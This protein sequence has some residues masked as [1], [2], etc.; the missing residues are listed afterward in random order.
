M[1]LTRGEASANVSANVSA[2]GSAPVS[3]SGPLRVLLA[4]SVLLPTLLFVFSSW[5]NYRSAVQDAVR[6]LERTSE[7]AREHA[8]KVFDGQAQVAERVND[9]IRGLDA[10]QIAGNEKRLHEALAGIVARLP[11][12]QSVMVASAEGRPLVSAGTYPVPRNVDLTGRDYFRAVMS[13]HEG[14]FVSSLQVGDVN[15]QLFFGMAAPWYGPG[16][17]RAGVID[18]AVSPDFFRDFYQALVNEGVGADRR[19]I[20]SLVRSDGQIL[21]RYPPLTGPPVQ[22]RGDN[23]F[24]AALR[25]QPDQGLFENASVVDPGSPDRLFYYRAVRGYPVYVVAGVARRQIRGVWEGTIARQLIFGVP[26]TVALFAVTWTALRR[27]RREEE[28]LRLARQEMRRRELA[29]QQLLHTQRLEAVGQMTGGVAHDFNNLLTIILGNAELIE[30]RADDPARVRRLASHVVLAARRGAEVTQKLLAFSRRQL[31]QPEVVDLNARLLEFREL[32]DRAAGEPVEVSF[33]LAPNLARVRLDPGQFEAA[34]LNL[35]GNAR[36]AMPEGGRVAITTRNVI[37][38]AG[39]RA[40]LADGVYAAVTVSDTGTG[41]DPATAAKAFEPFFTTKEVGRGTG[42]GLSQVY[43]FVKQ[44]GGDVRINT[45]PGAGT[46]V[47]LL[48]P[49]T[50]LAADPP[51]ADGLGS[52]GHGEVVLVVEDEKAVRDMAVE[53]LEELGYATV[54]APDAA[55]ALDRLRGPE[56]IDVLFSDVVMPGGLNGVKLATEAR[57]LRPGLRVLLTS[58]YSPD[59]IDSGLRLLR[60][61]YEREDLARNLKEI[62]HE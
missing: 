17:G 11:Q 32:L 44:A 12:V 48:L 33:D 24:F 2:P 38:E 6:D 56:R 62:L 61:P 59:A 60:K 1:R 27:T 7:V 30:R 52:A 39:E 46:G 58:G 5:L 14:I 15:R 20:V 43:G 28:A 51:A 41:M 19:E 40:D 23:P 37:L 42:L 8:T 21:A 22:L 26:A 10:D 25:E 47:E 57:R 55:G 54:T 50:N 16:G 36:D 9:L 34:I 49:R 29:E 53:A 18:T 4:A 35:V 3:A 31:V 13:G 45:A